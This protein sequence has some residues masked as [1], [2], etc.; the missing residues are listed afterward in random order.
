[1]T[2]R[3]QLLSGFRWTAGARFAAQIG[4]WAV[5][6]VVIRILSPSD[7]GLLAMATLF[8]AFLSM[9]GEFG[10]GSALVQQPEVDE[11]TLQRVFG[12]VL[13]V[14]LAL[15]VLL[16]LG[17]PLIAA[18]FSEP[19]VVPVVRVLSLQ[20][21]VAAFV[22]VPDAL[23]QREMKF[24]GRSLIELGAVLTG[25]AATLFLALA[26]YGVW[27]L[28]AGTLVAQLL[29]AIG[30]N[31]LVPYLRWPRFSLQGL[32][33]LLRFGGYTTL[34]QL[35]WALYVQ[36]DVLIGARLLG[37]E[38]L[39]FY[40]V[41]LHLASLPIQ[42]LSGIVNQ[43]AFPAFAR[44][45]D[46]LARVGAHVLAA[47][48]V[49]SV[50]A[51]PVLWGISS[52]APEI[53]DVILGPKWQS[54]ALPLQV[55]GLVMP[56]RVVAYFVP[57]AIQGIGRTDILLV[58]SLWGLAVAPPLLFLGAYHWGLAGLS[59]AW[60]VAS[61]LLFLQAMSRTLPA[62]G[63]RIAELLRAMAPAAGAGLVMY[64]TVAGARQILPVEL[65][66]FIQLAMLIIIGALAY[67]IASL[68]V[69]R[70]GIDEALALINGIVRWKRA[71]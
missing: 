27:A 41:A 29:K 69:N 31:V 54:A 5:T 48:R 46:D 67:T 12:I 6:L 28:V 38:A 56:L 17:A 8:I 71:R 60:L 65:G 33:P 61:P 64:G 11:A 53:A 23:L 50:V 20:F 3:A 13:L 14:H 51:F 47:T 44:L 2:F 52:I 55:L 59:L 32:R 21:I 37:K 25:S 66:G 35:L 19:R 58:N 42:R 36:V 34:L 68:L 62:I 10:L 30:L 70:K 7:Y 39:G 63:L 22:V 43:I 1:M 26:G 24:K 4:T 16:V 40:S 9:F 57:N 45:Q 49:L 18:F 15:A